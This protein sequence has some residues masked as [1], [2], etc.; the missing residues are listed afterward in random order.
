MPRTGVALAFSRA[1]AA[2]SG[3]LRAE[4]TRAN[5][6]G[7]IDQGMGP[8]LF[9]LEARRV[10]SMSDLAGEACVSRSTMTGVIDR[11]ESRGLVRTSKNPGDARGILVALTP[12]GRAV[13]PRL[14]EV[15]RRLDDAIG[16]TLSNAESSQLVDLLGKFAR[17]FGTDS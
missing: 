5:L 11:M 3:A 12:K 17:A 6:R 10:L 16:D 2:F 15:E 8:V 9:A 1:D 14:R 4:I 7:L 13:V